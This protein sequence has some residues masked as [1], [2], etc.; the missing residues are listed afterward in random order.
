MSNGLKVDDETK[1]TDTDDIELETALQ[2][3]LLNLL[4]DAVETDVALRKDR[5]LGV[6]VHHRH[7]GN[8]Q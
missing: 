5:G 8:H 3:L 6:R 7:C 1:L 4:C 2:Q